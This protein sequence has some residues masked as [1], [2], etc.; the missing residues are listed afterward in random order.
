MTMHATRRAWNALVDG[1]AAV[2]T[3]L[4][5]VLMLIICSDVVARN[6]LG[7]SLPLV[8]EL[9]A[10]TLVMIVYLQL[11]AAIRHDRLART[12]LVFGALRASRPRLGA[13][14]SAAFD[15]V[16]AAAL[17]ALAWSTISILE[18]DLRSGQFIGVTGVMTAPTWPF[19]VLIVAGLAVSAIQFAIQVVEALRAVA[20]PREEKTS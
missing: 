12:E 17:A 16:G 20:A 9:G 1:L 19:R 18:R 14:L 8:S 3:L 10:L 11:A 7:A 5:G 2:G 6:L 13:A 4:I 15:L